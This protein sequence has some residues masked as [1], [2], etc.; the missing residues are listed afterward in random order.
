M[1]RYGTLAAPAL[2]LLRSL[3]QE[4]LLT[5]ARLVGGTGLAL[6][7][8][9]RVSYDLDFFGDIPDD[10]QEIERMLQRYGVVT[11]LK[12]SGR[13]KVYQ[14]DGIKVDLVSYDYP[15]IAAP[16]VEDG[17]T[18]ASDKDIAAMKVHAIQNRG[19]KKDF[20]D[21]YCLL[22]RYTLREII[23][24]YKTK[25]RDY[26]VFRALLSLNY[27]ADAEQQTAPPT[28][29]DFDWEHTKDFISQCVT[30]FDPMK[31]SLSN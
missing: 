8:G 25:F 13:V 28:F 1:L 7:Y 12:G 27:F 11:V 21:L 20:I 5:G 26:S 6:Q 17:L 15:W 4:A 18:I 3:M 30:D 9:H 31:D 29:F 16:V 19:S 2:T 24:F 23:G 22:Q 10:S 14:V